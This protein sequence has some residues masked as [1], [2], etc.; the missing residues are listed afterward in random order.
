MNDWKGVYKNINSK[1]LHAEL[2]SLN[3]RVLN[4]GVSLDLKNPWRKKNK[5]VLCDKKDKTRN[6]IFLECE[7]SKLIFEKVKE[8][9]IKKE[10]ELSFVYYCYGLYLNDIILISIFKLAIWKCINIVKKGKM[11]KPEKVFC[12]VF[13]ACVKNMKNNHSKKKK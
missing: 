6:H 13:M 11:K 12:S 5:S 3:F 4:N 8:R 9:F 7:N 2:R 1:K 10:V